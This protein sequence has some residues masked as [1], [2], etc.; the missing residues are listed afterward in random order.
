MTGSFLPEA[1]AVGLLSPEERAA[2]LRAR[3]ND[4]R[5]DRRLDDAEAMF[6]PL[7]GAAGYIAPPPSLKARILDA[8]GGTRNAY[9]HGE[10]G[11]VAVPGEWFDLFPGVEVKQLWSAGPSLVRCAPISVIPAHEHLQDEYIAVL[12]GD[13]T[14]DGGR[15][16][17][18]D[19]LFSPRGSRHG[20]GTTRFGCMLLVQEG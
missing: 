11:N 10:V 9:Q 19:C 5:L 1:F 6:A 3:H 4:S 17:A 13:L 2:V 16:G 8:V 15:L 14:I 18:G 7:A 12:S 20:D